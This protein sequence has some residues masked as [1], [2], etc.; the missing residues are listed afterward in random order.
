[1]FKKL[2]ATSAIF[3]GSLSTAFATGSFYL[4]PSLTYMDLTSDVVNYTGLTPGLYLGYGA[5]ARD[6]LNLSVEVFGKTKSYNI[7]SNNKDSINLKTD[8]NLGISLVPAA[9]LDNVL[10]GFLRLGYVRTKFSSFDETKGGFQLGVGIEGEL[11]ECWN[12]RG[13]FDYTQYNSLDE[14]GTVKSK[15]VTLALIYRFEPLV[16]NNV[17]EG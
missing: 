16:S 4:G 11:V 13:E 12:L 1:M 10:L 17:G 7:D 9:N 3:V 15:E 2:L 6:W 8:Y 14:I 5:W